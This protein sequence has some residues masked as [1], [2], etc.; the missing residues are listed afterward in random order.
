[1]NFRILL[2][3]SLLLLSSLF[4]VRAQNVSVYTKDGGRIDYAEG[5]VVSIEFNDVERPDIN[6]PEN[7][8]SIDLGLSV[9]WASCNVGATTPEDTG[10]YMAWGE[11]TEKSDYCWASY[12]DEN[13]ERT[14]TSICGMADYDVATAMWGDEW[15]LP[16]LAE[17]QELCDRCT[18]SWT[19]QNGQ[20]GCTVTGPNGQSIFL[21]A[22]GTRQG[23]GLYLKSSYGSFLTGTRDD[24]NRF[25]ARSLVFFSTGEHWIDTNLRDYGQSIRPVC[26]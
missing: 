17:M 5:E 21:P 26:K 19:E 20:K 16:T 18:W 6:A 2:S 23:T 10:S 14:L 11:M 7:V 4:E 25:Y 3:F 12:F 13:C 22:G 24:S 9:K 1:M 15:R 8:H